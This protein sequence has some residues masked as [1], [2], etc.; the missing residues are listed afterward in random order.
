MNQNYLILKLITKISN[1]NE[2]GVTLRLPSKK[3]GESIN[4]GN[5]P[6]KLLLIDSNVK[7]CKAFD[8]KLI[9]V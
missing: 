5:F 1:K 7:L 2:T 9:T 8:E 6:Q 4:E 3:V